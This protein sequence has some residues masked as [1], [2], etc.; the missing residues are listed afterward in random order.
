MIVLGQE[1]GIA[2]ELGLGFLKNGLAY[3]RMHKALKSLAHE[4]KKN[5]RLFILLLI[6]YTN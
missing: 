6:L 4:K 1:P 3:W 2:F 5:H